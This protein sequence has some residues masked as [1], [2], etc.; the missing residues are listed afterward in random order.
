[1]HTNPS[2]LRITNILNLPFTAKSKKLIIVKD[3]MRLY[4]LYLLSKAQSKLKARKSMIKFIV[5]A[6]A[7]KV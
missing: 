4:N 2:N 3:Q 6:A 7:V 5:G 1:M